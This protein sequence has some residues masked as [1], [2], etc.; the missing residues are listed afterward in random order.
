M[1]LCYNCRRPGNIA[2]EFPRVGPISLC[3]KIF[4]HEF[5]DCPRIIAKVEGKDIR[6]ENFEKSQETKGMLEIH[7]KKGQ[8]KFIICYYSWKKRWMFTKMSVYQKS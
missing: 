1:T 4:G 3:F 6:Q 5:E 8:R 7:K 2:K